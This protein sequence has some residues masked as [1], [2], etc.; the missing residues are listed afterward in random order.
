M[1]C[2]FIIGISHSKCAKTR[3]LNA[4]IGILFEKTASFMKN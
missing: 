3:Y 4:N 1:N 2:L